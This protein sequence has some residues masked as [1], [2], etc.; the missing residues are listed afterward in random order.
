MQS[1]RPYRV[2]R[3]AKT[4]GHLHKL[5]MCL[6]A[7]PN[8]VRICTDSRVV[9]IGNLSGIPSLS[10]RGT[11]RARGSPPPTSRWGVRFLVPL[12]APNRSALATVLEDNQNEFLLF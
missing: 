2:R 11:S 12:P 9:P 1:S 3:P 10:H 5:L 4:F 6:S 8:T 7:L